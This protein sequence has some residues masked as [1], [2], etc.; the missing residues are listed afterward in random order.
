V[1][2]HNLKDLERAVYADEDL[3]FYEKFYISYK[4]SDLV[5]NVWNNEFKIESHK[6]NIV[7]ETSTRT[8]LISLC[9]GNYDN[10]DS[11]TLKFT[12]GSA[13][14]YISVYSNKLLRNSIYLEAPGMGSG[15]GVIVNTL[16]VNHMT[17]VTLNSLVAVPNKDSPVKVKEEWFLDHMGY[18]TRKFYIT[19]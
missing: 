10:Y 12:L 17:L 18:R 4:Y 11:N 5:I 8:D 13:N 7:S 19:K 9:T 14:L 2:E 6:G 16:A 15:N 1:P 3:C